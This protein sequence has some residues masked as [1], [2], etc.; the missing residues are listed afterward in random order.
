M[1]KSL[2][3]KISFT[4]R[5]RQVNS[6]YFVKKLFESKRFRFDC[7]LIKYPLGGFVLPHRDPVSY[8]KHHRLNIELVKATRGGKFLGNVC[9][10]VGRIVKF[11][12]DETFHEVTEVQQGVRYVL[13]IGWISGT[14]T[15]LQVL[16]RKAF[17]AG[18]VARNT[19]RG[20]CIVPQEFTMSPLKEKF[21]EGYSS[22]NKTE[23]VVEDGI[24]KAHD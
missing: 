5:G 16:K 2:L 24:C 11:M 6:N 4:E 12:P 9:F 21:L 22:V 15:P 23:E 17:D 18:V 20:T 19:H 13:S 3:N 10:K 1:L 7:H 14:N 8:G